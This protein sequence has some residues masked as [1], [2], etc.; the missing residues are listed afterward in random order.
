[1]YDM[2][3]GMRVIEGASFVAGPYC[4]LMLAQLGAEIIRFDTIG[5]GPDFNRWP[6]ADNG[7]SFYWEGLN[8]SKKSIALNLASPEGRELATALI[9]APGENAGIFVTNYPV[10]GFLAHERLAA[11]RPDLITARVMGH[12]DGGSAVDYTINSGIGYPLMTGP[13][14]PGD[15]PVNHVLPAW[16][17]LTGSTAAL[18][19]M[20]ALRLR[21]ASGL[22]GEIRVPLS[23]VAAATL[24]NLGQI[25]EVLDTGQ[26]RPRYGNDLFGAFGRDF[27]TSDGQRLMVVGLTAKQ[28]SSL[29]DALDLRPAVTALEAELGTSFASDEGT[30]FQH[31]EKLNPLVAAAIAAVDAETL[32]RRFREHGV[33]WGPYR[34]VKQALDT[35]PELSPANP[36]FAEV[37]HPS[38]QAYLT[39]GFPSTFRELPRQ[40]PRRAPALGEHT[41]EVLSDILGLPHHEIARLHDAGVVQSSNAVRV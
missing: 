24:G 11:R 14:G 40:T 10:D 5:G 3:A 30:R 16:D 22:G 1:M 13:A 39:P 2:L 41:E 26:D 21:T 18:S 29:L 38:G 32:I 23:D 31:R 37:R 7:A 6:R 25:A 9:T 35:D 36:L 12:R 27:V 4:A 19:V 34:S 28:W 33:A 15:E 20:A 17:L 8:K